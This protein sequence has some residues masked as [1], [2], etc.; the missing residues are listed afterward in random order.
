MKFNR[1]K[2]KEFSSIELNSKKKIEKFDKI[3]LT[4]FGVVLMLFGSDVVKHKPIF[5]MI[6]VSEPQIEI[7]DYDKKRGEYLKKLHDYRECFEDDAL[8]N[9][10]KDGKIAVT[11]NGNTIEVNLKALYLRY[12]EIEGTKFVFL[13]NVLNGRNVDFFTNSDNSYAEDYS[14]VEF[15]KTT[16]FEKLYKKNLNPIFNNTMELSEDETLELIKMINDW[17]GKLNDIVPETMAIEEKKIWEDSSSGKE[18]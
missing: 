5:Q 10:Y 15:R 18:R 7:S 4:S 6:D 8:Y 11:Y 17:D 12:G 2:S 14:I 13:S 1:E 16:I 9:F 3:I